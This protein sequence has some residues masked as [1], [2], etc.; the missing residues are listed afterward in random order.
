[1]TKIAAYWAESTGNKTVRRPLPKSILIK[2]VRVENPDAVFLP[3]HKVSIRDNSDENSVEL[4]LSTS[5]YATPQEAITKA[6]DALNK[7]SHKLEELEI[8]RFAF[9]IENNVG[10][11]PKFVKL[12][13]GTRLFLPLPSDSLRAYL[14]EALIDRLKHST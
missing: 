12:P 5:A 14:I 7:P 6:I 2:V 10:Y 8:K 3:L 11:G 1:M 9:Q 4:I 13:N